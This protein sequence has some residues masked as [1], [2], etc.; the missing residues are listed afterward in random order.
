LTHIEHVWEPAGDVVEEGVHRREPLV[1][2][3]RAVFPVL[4]EVVQEPQYALE[5]EIL[6]REARDFAPLGRPTDVHPGGHG[7]IDAPGRPLARADGRRHDAAL[8]A[9]VASVPLR[10]NAT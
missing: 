10:V 8:R 6:D 3:L 1:S 9:D 5:R 4:L 2:C 7:P